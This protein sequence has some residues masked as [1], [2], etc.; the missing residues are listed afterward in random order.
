MEFGTS[1]PMFT[2]LATLAMIN[3]VSLVWAAKRAVTD[4]GV[5]VFETVALQMVLCG[6]LVAINVPLYSA[7]LFRQDNGKIPS[8]IAAKSVLLAVFVCT[9]SMFLL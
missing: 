6:V 8:S 2:V 5:R 7:L 1:F 4:A 9:C 3:L